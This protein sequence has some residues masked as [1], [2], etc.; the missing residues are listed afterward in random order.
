MK[1]R[2]PPARAG[3]KAARP[4]A[5]SASKVAR[6]AANM[7]RT[8]GGVVDD[9]AT[10]RKAKAQGAVSPGKVQVDAKGFAQRP[11][12]VEDAFVQQ[13]RANRPVTQLS[14]DAI[15]AEFREG[16]RFTS[17]GKL[18]KLDNNAALASRKTE[19]AQLR[20]SSQFE[21][22][23][24]ARGIS[25]ERIKWMDE[26][27]CPLSFDSPKQYEEFPAQSSD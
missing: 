25:E 26:K 7:T 9:I 27:K 5:T 19:N 6:P 2:Q 20:S 11:N 14:D 21:S 17:T 22:D 12:A 15:R 8:G 13:Y 3:A 18:E 10:L 4:V 23:V 24:K 16:K 1:P